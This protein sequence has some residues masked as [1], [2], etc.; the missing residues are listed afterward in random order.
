MENIGPGRILPGPIFFMLL[1]QWGVF[2]VGW[3]ASV[4]ISTRR[5]YGQ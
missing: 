1:G 3:E 4:A 2:L 5:H